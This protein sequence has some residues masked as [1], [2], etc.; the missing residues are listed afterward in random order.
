LPRRKAGALAGFLSGSGSAICCLTLEDP[1]AVAAAMLEVAHRPARMII[2]TADN[3][4][5][6]G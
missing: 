1:E 4:G 2:T 6:V 3:E 5:A